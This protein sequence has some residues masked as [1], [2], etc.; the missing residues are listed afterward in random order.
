VEFLN[1]EEILEFAQFVIERVT[2]DFL[3]EG[4]TYIIQTGYE[5]I[6]DIILLYA[7]QTNLLEG[8]LLLIENNM[9]EEALILFR[10]QINNYMLIRYL[11]KANKQNERL[12]KFSFQPIKSELRFLKNI[13]KGLKKGWIQDREYK[14]LD[15]KIAEYET[16]L[17]EN[18]FVKWENGKEKLDLTHLTIHELAQ[19]DKLLFNIYLAY[20]N[21]GSKYE[22]S[23]PSSLE[24]YR[25]KIID[26]YSNM[27]V[28]K[29]NLSKTDT[30][31]ENLVLN[32]S[33]QMYC[34]TYM[35]LIK[36]LKDEY[37]H[38]FGDEKRKNKLL[39]LLLFIDRVMDQKTEDN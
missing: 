8:I 3:Q 33:V 19:Q 17:K 5:H 10:S 6:R 34:L 7:K 2:E 11:M 32:Q 36:Y 21:L 38:L 9:A 22:H 37:I 30:D 31:L 12:K 27:S 18:G 1:K 14:G 28:F 26:E 13:K 24:I 29:M 23:D 35:Q 25:E 15:K 20:Y 16:L 4:K 39:K